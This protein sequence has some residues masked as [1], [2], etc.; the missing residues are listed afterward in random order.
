MKPGVLAAIVVLAVVA[1]GGFLFVSSED[2]TDTVVDNAA[3]NQVSTTAEPA[4][5]NDPIPG[6]DASSAE[7]FTE[8]E[9]A[10]HA[11]EDDCWTIVDGSVYDITAYVPRHPGGVNAISRA[12]GTDGSSLFNERTDSDGEELGS[13]TPHSSNAT[14]QLAGFKLG[15]LE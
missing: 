14:N 7:T 2:S 8:A 10:M 15:E 12:C 4:G 11:S 6:E 3:T 1:V 5:A 9:V 13:G